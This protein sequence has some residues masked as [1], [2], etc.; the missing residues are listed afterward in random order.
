MDRREAV[1]EDW[2]GDRSESNL[3]RKKCKAS[4]F[5]GGEMEGGT[6]G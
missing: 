2:Q 3:G 6:W 1:G 5:S 4:S